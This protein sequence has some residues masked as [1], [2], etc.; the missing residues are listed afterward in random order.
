[1]SLLDHML[2]EPEDPGWC[3][4]HSAPRP[5]VHCADEAADRDD[6]D[7]REERAAANA[8]YRRKEGRPER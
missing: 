1:M 5:C 3:H 4:V 6:M 8:A 7:A 2:E